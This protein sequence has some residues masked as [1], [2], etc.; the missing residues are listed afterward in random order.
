MARTDNTPSSLTDRLTLDETSNFFLKDTNIPD[1][2]VVVETHAQNKG[3]YTPQAIGTAHPTLN[4]YFLYEESVTDIGNGI[5]KIS[6]K[7]AVTPS[8]WYSFE[9]QNI[10]FTKFVGVSV[11]GSGNIIITES[12]L[13][14]WLNLQGIEDVRD[15]KESVYSTSEQKQGSINCVVRVKH[16]YKAVDLES[17]KNGT[18]APFTIATADYEPWSDNGELGSIDD[19]IDFTFT[20]SSPSLPIKYEAGKYAGNIYYNK[21]YEIVSTFTI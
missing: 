13:F 4:K 10:P 6:S 20:T 19:D 12:F 17:I 18:L 21:T 1:S 16:E 7:Y 8:T 15:F 5:F 14:G 11:V 9:A 2:Y 3:D